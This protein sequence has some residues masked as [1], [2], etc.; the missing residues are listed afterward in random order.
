[1]KVYL[2][3][4]SLLFHSS[5]GMAGGHALSLSREACMPLQCGQ[6]AR[7]RLS[8]TGTE[9]LLRIGIDTI[10]DNF[11][12]KDLANE[13]LDKED[14][15]FQFNIG[16]EASQISAQI[17]DL[18]FNAIEFGN[19][20]VDVEGDNIHVCVPVE[21]MDM[22]VDAQ[23][24]IK[25]HSTSHKG[26]RAF[27]NPDSPSKPKVC[28]NGEIGL[29]GQV[30]DLVH[31][32]NDVPTDIGLE[33]K[34][35]MLDMDLENADEDEILFTY[36]SLYFMEDNL[37][38]P[39]KFDWLSMSSWQDVFTLVGDIT[40]ENMK[41][42]MDMDLMKNKLKEIKG[43]LPPRP[44]SDRPEEG[45]VNYLGNLKVDLNLEENT[46]KENPNADYL[47]QVWNIWKEESEA[48]MKAAPAEE[49]AGGLYGLWRKAADAV[50]GF[51][52]DVV[53]SAQTLK[54]GFLQA[55]A[56]QTEEL[57][58]SRFLPYFQES[59]NNSVSASAPVM[60][61][62][63]KT[64]EKHLIPLA[65]KKANEAISKLQN[66]SNFGSITRTE[67]SRPFINAQ[68]LVDRESLNRIQES[69]NMSN[70]SIISNQVRNIRDMPNKDH[71]IEQTDKIL[72]NISH[73]VDS[74]SSNS[75]D[76]NAQN[77]LS[78]TL[79][80]YLERLRDNMY[81]QTGGH[82]PKDLKDKTLQLIQ[83]TRAKSAIVAENISYRN[84]NLELELST[85][86][87]N[88]LS[89]GPEV[90]VA[91]EELCAQGVGSI[92]ESTKVNNEE[93]QSYDLSGTLNIDAVNALLE[94]LAK[95][96]QFDFCLHNGEVQTCSSV[97]GNYN[98]RCRFEDPPRVTWNSSSQKH[99]IKLRD[100][101]C[102]T[103]ILNAQEK[104]G[105]GERRSKIP[106]LGFFV[107][108]LGS[109]A[110]GACKFISDQ[111]DNVVTGSIGQNL[112][113]VT[114]ELEPEICGNSVCMEPHLKD[115][116]IVTDMENVNPN[117]AS[118]IGKLVGIV[119][120][121]IT[122][123]VKNEIVDDALMTFVESEVSQPLRAPIGIYPQKIVSERGRITVLSNIE[124]EEDLGDFF[125]ECVTGGTNCNTEHFL[126]IDA[127]HQSE[128]RPSS[129]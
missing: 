21:E 78:E 112:V 55:K 101:Q 48:E 129:P 5:M 54:D 105:I 57:I 102:E 111:A 122:D 34:M 9:K 40:P 73:Y 86:W 114:V 51:K 16:S 3:V 68:D 117:L 61:A 26:A 119:T 92:G 106:V 13:A 128:R 75:S 113:D 84:R 20:E 125:A 17:D 33:T 38:L 67:L 52:D 124:P 98:N 41:K 103:R 123:V 24:D 63:A 96:G 120:S 28:F 29:D 108:A 46:T 69:M 59:F 36:M 90:T 97:T 32:E 44:K 99:E 1:M 66:A 50:V 85:R 82:I 72:R 30:K 45:L 31:I 6:M 2:M 104:C 79:I 115:S 76:R 15:P 62:L 53:Q 74:V 94:K 7:L 65:K 107:N 25:G 89:G 77:Y 80:P 127:S 19:S 8:H 126:N 23:L 118:M 22:S 49:P 121:P 27:V 109:L 35:A 43:S 39:L 18:T 14:F 87:F 12:L 81:Y 91:T 83:E 37:D 116:K 93:L 4:V 11:D 56:H 64:A 71:I 42:M 47:D 60:G 70:Y 110:G 10:T 100:L 88:E 58:R 95:D